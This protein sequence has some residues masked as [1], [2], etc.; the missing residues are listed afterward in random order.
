MTASTLVLRRPRLWPEAKTRAWRAV[1]GVL[2]TS[3]APTG[4]GASGSGRAASNTARGLVT[5]E[6]EGFEDVVELAAH[7]DTA[8][9]ETLFRRFYEP[10]LRYTTARCGFRP[11]AEDITQETFVTAVRAIRTFRARDE[12]SVQAWLLTIARNTLTDRF[13]RD[14]RGDE[15]LQEV[16]ARQEGDAGASDATDLAMRRIEAQEIRQALELLTEDQR[17]IIIRRFVLDHSLEDVAHATNRPVGA[18]KSLQHR[19]LA[20]LNRL[21]TAEA[22]R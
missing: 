3:Q 19:A 8:A 18:V 20:S 16:G 15:I 14:R 12:L 7:G 6:P 10:V 13:R 5:P 21:M 2:A 17:E 9:W 22:T 1:L 11:L 4:T